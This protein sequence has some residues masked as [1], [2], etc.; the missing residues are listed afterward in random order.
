MLARYRDRFPTPSTPRQMRYKYAVQCSYIST[1]LPQR[2]NRQDP[3][4]RSVRPPLIRQKPGARLLQPHPP[5]R[6][7]AILIRRARV[8]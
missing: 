7:T 4:K 1:S 6:R 3:P 5:R 2:I 8:L